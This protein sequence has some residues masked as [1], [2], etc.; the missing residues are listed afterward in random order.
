MDMSPIEY[1]G[2]H[3]LPVPEQAGVVQFH[4]FQID[5]S[6]LQGETIGKNDIGEA[7]YVMLL[8]HDEN[9]VRIDDVFEAVFADPL[10]YA[11]GLAGMNIFGTF[12]KKTE[13]AGIWFSQFLNGT[14]LKLFMANLKEAVAN[15]NNSTVSNE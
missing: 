7:Y 12:V 6:G 4:Y 5:E 9:G 15:A 13:D 14:I 3:M 2:F 8:K 10:V 1:D 11:K